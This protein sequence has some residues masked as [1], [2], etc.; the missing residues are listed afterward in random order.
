MNTRL[1]PLALIVALLLSLG[2]VVTACGDDDGDGNGGALTLDEYFEEAGALNDAFSEQ[3]DE[4]DVDME[5]ALAALE[6][7]GEIL[8]LFD[9]SFSDQLDNVRDFVNG[10]A[11]L[12]PPAEVKDAHDEAVEAFRDFTDLLEDYLDDL[13]DAESFTDF[14]VL[15]DTALNEANELVA[16]ACLAVE[17]IAADNGIDVDLDCGE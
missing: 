5:E 14:E 13:G 4:L 1:I 9:Q 2:A 3:G 6:D 8:D 17:E 15:D 12:D 16:A 10:L 11:D 7:E